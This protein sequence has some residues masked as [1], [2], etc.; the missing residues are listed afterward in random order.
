MIA[1]R[2]KQITLMLILVSVFSYYMYV[3]L[4]PVEQYMGWVVREG[5][6]IRYSVTAEINSGTTYVANLL[7]DYGI[8]SGSTLTIRA[9]E[10]P[11]NVNITAIAGAL[12][13]LSGIVQVEQKNGQEWITRNSSLPFFLPVGCWDSIEHA[14]NQFMDVD[15]EKNWWGEIDLTAPYSSPELGSLGL[16]LAWELEDGVLQGMTINASTYDGWDFVRLALSYQNLA[17]ETDWDLL[18]RSFGRNIIRLILTG[19]MLG[20]IFLFGLLWQSEIRSRLIKPLNGTLEERLETYGREYL[21]LWCFG[22]VVSA[23]AGIYGSQFTQESI[24]PVIQS[25]IFSFLL[26]TLVSLY[27][28][29]RIDHT[30]APLEVIQYAVASATS[31][32]IGVFIFSPFEV[33]GSFAYALPIVMFVGMMVLLIVMHPLRA[34]R[35]KL[36]LEREEFEDASLDYNDGHPNEYS[37]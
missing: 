2:K 24:F 9:A 18:S 31:T 12:S 19:G 32:I 21:L 35:S 22:A 34:L 10:V 5:D 28:V 7:D 26:G 36:R 13:N 3:T 11:T 8:S 37:L 23:F 20:P 30:T 16:F 25:Y 1:G 6:E 14:L 17:Y 29:R 33:E 27:R 4:P 15:L